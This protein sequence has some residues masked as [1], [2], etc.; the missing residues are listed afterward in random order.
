MKISAV[1]AATFIITGCLSSKIPDQ[2]FASRFSEY[3]MLAEER[4]RRS[5]SPEYALGII[6]TYLDSY[7]CISPVGPE[8]EA[9]MF[10]VVNYGR[11]SRILLAMGNERSAEAFEARALLALSQ[12]KQDLHPRWQSVTNGA[13]FFDALEE[14]DGLPEF[15]KELVRKKSSA[16]GASA[17]G[18]P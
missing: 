5:Q 2:D 8:A 9:S 17:I 1:L 10:Q 13:S 4:Y 18:E 7:H 15:E 6:M 16:D 3:G 14:M 11:M 12:I